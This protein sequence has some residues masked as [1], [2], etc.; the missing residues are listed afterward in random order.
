MQIEIYHDTV[1]PWCRIGKR[2]LQL[3][4][5]KFTDEP[6][7]ITY[8]TFFLNDAIPPQGADFDQVMRAKLG[9]QADIS[10]EPMFDGPRR[11]GARV[12]L[13]F[14]FE[15]I[16]VAPNTTLS[17]RL[18]ALTPDAQKPAVVDAIYKA[19]FEDGADI[20]QLETLLA[21]AEA[22]GLS[23]TETAQALRSDAMEAVVL[24]E[25]DQAHAMGITG[26]P[27]FVFNGRYAASG[28]Q[29]P[30]AMLNILRQVAARSKAES[31]VTG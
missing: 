24:A 18:I 16:R 17:H 5:E 25:V 15:K 28:A 1:C 27:F 22:V 30:D 14:N 4:L 21:I 23:R 7:T 11:M 3:A 31:S 6:T 13:T 19:Y 9:G 20:G 2:N 10:L 29:P 8:R 12:G 26:V